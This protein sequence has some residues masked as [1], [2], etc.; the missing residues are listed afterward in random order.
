[1]ESVTNF[2][3]AHPIAMIAAVGVLLVLLLVMFFWDF[4]WTAT[5]N[6]E[7]EKLDALI[8]EVENKQT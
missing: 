6:S 1:M 8:T 4:K 5:K 2:V 3:S 7:E